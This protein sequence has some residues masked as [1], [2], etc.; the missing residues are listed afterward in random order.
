MFK[1]VLLALAASLMIAFS[2]VYAAEKINLN[3][4]SAEEL[5][6]LNGIGPAIAQAIVDYRQQHGLFKSVSELSAV[7]GIGEKKVE[8]LTESV[9][10]TE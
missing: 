3:T 4:A 6:T 9:T 5:E 2:S 8:K 1:H 7:K 10:V